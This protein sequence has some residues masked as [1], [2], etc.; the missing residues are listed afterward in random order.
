M[1]VS[2]ARKK[3]QQRMNRYK[4]AVHPAQTEHQL[5]EAPIDTSGL[6][7]ALR[8]MRVDDAGASFRHQTI[9]VFFAEHRREPPDVGPFSGGEPLID[10]RTIGIVIRHRRTHPKRIDVSEREIS[11]IPD[12]VPAQISPEERACL[13]MAFE[14]FTR[15]LHNHQIVEN[16][17]NSGETGPPP[18][19]AFSASAVIRHGMGIMPE[20]VTEPLKS[21]RRLIP[22]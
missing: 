17:V 14:L 20:Q 6:N 8:Q 2:H 12:F 18:V 7:E 19:H 15:S 10:E 11:D 1:A 5:L 4:P 13:D 3:V 9:L 22:R 16:T 21:F